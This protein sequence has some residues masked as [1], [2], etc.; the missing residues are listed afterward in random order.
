MQPLREIPEVSRMSTLRSLD[1]HGVTLL[2]NMSITRADHGALIGHRYFNE[3]REIRLEAV[4]G[5][6]WV[7]MQQVNDELVK[8]LHDAGVAA[9]HV[10]GDARSPRRLSHALAEGHRAAR[11]V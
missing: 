7:G 11:A 10:V 5:L 8:Q 2:D 4:R 6:A 9:V 1:R 3:A